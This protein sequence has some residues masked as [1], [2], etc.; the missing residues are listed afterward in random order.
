MNSRK[1]KKANKHSKQILIDWLRENVS[2]EEGKLLN[3][4]NVEKFLPQEKYH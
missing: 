2:E 4:D 1:A 3:K